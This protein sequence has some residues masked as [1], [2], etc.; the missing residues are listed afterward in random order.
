MHCKLPLK[1]SQVSLETLCWLY[2]T[3][4]SLNCFINFRILNT[5]T[6]TGLWYPTLFSGRWK[7]PHKGTRYSSNVKMKDKLKTNERL[8]KIHVKKKINEI[9]KSGTFSLKI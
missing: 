9:K 6:K 4:V 5:H 3:P 7:T 2:L 8:K 1:D